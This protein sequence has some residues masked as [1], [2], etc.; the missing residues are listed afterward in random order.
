LQS[1]KVDLTEAF[2]AGGRSA[3][4]VGPSRQ[5][6]NVLVTAQLALTMV[7]LIGAALMIQSFRNLGNVGPGFNTD[8]L[9]TMELS[10]PVDSYPQPRRAAVMQQLIE[11]TKTVPGMVS[12]AAAKHLPL[13]GDNMNFAFDI[14]T[15]PFPEGK[16]PGADCRIVTSNYF[17]TLGIPLVKGRFFTDGDDLP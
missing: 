7:L 8:R 9:L 3:T 13:S 12:V 17:S 2:K 14:E 4:E 5:F 15:R 10:V 1:I 16:S 6:R 11:R